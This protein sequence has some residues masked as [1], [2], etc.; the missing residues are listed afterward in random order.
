MRI[1]NCAVE[2]IQAVN[3]TVNKTN[4]ETEEVIMYPRDS[5]ERLIAGMCSHVSYFFEALAFIQGIAATSSMFILCDMIS[6]YSKTGS[7]KPQGAVALA[8]TVL[9]QVWAGCSIRNGRTAYT[10]DKQETAGDTND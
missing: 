3:V 2:N 5:V 9:A 4:G 1:K 8:L 6:I 7:I 10:L